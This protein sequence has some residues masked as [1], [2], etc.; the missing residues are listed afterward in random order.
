MFI[1]PYNFLFSLYDDMINMKNVLQMMNFSMEELSGMSS[2]SELILYQVWT[3]VEMPKF[4][5]IPKFQKS[6]LGWVLTGMSSYHKKWWTWCSWTCFISSIWYLTNLNN[7][8]FPQ[9]LKYFW[10]KNL[11][12]SIFNVWKMSDNRIKLLPYCFQRTQMIISSS[13]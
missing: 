12:V 2:S 4:V 13:Q 10:I 9:K 5:K 6:I 1:M 8:K 3:S 7:L 11:W